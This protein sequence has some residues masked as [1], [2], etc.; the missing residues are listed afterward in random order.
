MVQKEE[1]RDTLKIKNQVSV[2]GG[3]REFLY[4]PTY[5]NG[6]LGEPSTSDRVCA[7]GDTEW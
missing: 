3:E 2:W 7:S 5:M 6:E 1:E 4:I